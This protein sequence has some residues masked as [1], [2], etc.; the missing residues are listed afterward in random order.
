MIKIWLIKTYKKIRKRMEVIAMK[1]KI[2]MIKLM[3][4]KMMTKVHKKNHH[5]QFKKTKTEVPTQGQLKIPMFHLNFL[6]HLKVLIFL[7]TKT[8]SK[9]MIQLTSLN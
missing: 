8:S 4:I 3:T 5:L 7:S 6:I 2:T 1:T 9:D